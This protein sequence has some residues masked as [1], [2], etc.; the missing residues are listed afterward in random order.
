MHVA[1]VGINTFRLKYNK[2]L[3][4]IKVGALN[5]FG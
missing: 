4:L 1:N 5:L 2:M 3:R